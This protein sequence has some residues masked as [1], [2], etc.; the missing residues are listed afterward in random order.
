M[1]A[2]AWRE[3]LRKA[4]IGSEA[5]TWYACWLRDEEGRD[6]LA[7]GLLWLVAA[8]HYP[9]YREKEQWVWAYSDSNRFYF[10]STDHI[11]PP[12]CQL[13][14]DVFAA[15]PGTPRYI[16]GGTRIYQERIDAML[17]AAEAAAECGKIPSPR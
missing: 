8:G 12:H 13:P 10:H 6:D 7:D 2:T 1:N 11:I 5:W 16:G 14:D 3:V 17:A 9:H 15:L 4:T